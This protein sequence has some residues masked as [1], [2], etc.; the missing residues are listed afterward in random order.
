MI[1]KGKF[2]DD[3]RALPK[4][5]GCITHDGPHF[6]HMQEILHEKNLKLLE[7]QSIFAPIAFSREEIARLRELRIELLR[8]WLIT[9]DDWPE[10]KE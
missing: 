7:S 10:W 8:R 4:D 3:L 6:V 5:C 1:L 2:W 9:P